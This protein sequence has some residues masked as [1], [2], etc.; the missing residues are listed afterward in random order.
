MSGKEKCKLLKE[1]RQRIAEEN[2]IEY[3]GKPCSFEGDCKGT[4][5]ACDRELTDLT[6]KVNK[7]GLGMT[8][9]VC[10]SLFSLGLSGCTSEAA[11]RFIITGRL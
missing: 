3:T 1:L 2:N 4:C 5:P 6:Q 9:A 10:I 8:A 7:L 11:A